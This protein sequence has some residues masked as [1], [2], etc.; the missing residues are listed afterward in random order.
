MADILLI[1]YPGY[2][3]TMRE[4]YLDNGLANLAGALRSASHNP[5]VL[6]Y[7]NPELIDWFFPYS[8]GPAINEIVA[9]L[10]A[11]QKAGKVPG[12]SLIE[13]F[14]ETDDAVNSFQEK[15]LEEFVKSEIF[16]HIRRQSP[17]VIGFKL[18][19]GEGFKFAVRIAEMIKKEFPGIL[20]V[21][22]GA[23]V[24]WFGE[25]IY[26]SGMGNVFDLLSYGEGEEIIKQIALLPEG[27]VKLEDIP[28]I[29]Y[30]K[31]PEIITNSKKL[32]ENL[33]DLPEPIY[34]P[35]VYRPMECDKKIRVL[36]I[37]ESR[38]CPNKCAF[39]IHP[40]KSGNYWRERKAV[41]VVDEMQRHVEKYRTN[42]F[43]FAGSNPPPGLKRDIAR[44]IIKRKLKVRYGAFGHARGMDQKDY[45]L[46]KE[47]GCVSLF[48][49]VE[50]GSQVIL[51]RAM[52]KGNRVEQVRQSLIMCREAGIK[53]IASVIVPAPFDNESTVN[54]TFELLAAAKPF[55]VIVNLPGALPKTAWFD[56]AARYGFDVGDRDAFIRNSMVYSIKNFYPP[57]LWR[58]L[59]GYTL[60]G[61]PAAD[62]IKTT[63]LFTKRLHAAG[64][65]TRITDDLSLIVD[66]LGADKNEFLNTTWSMLSSGDSRGIKEMI[67]K[68][69]GSIEAGMDMA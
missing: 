16:S 28:N 27:G 17:Q 61:K 14:H 33:E 63:S 58:D 20:L 5:L 65:S 46:L 13:K 30:R 24:D 60:D 43:R 57:A 50:S 54:E 69:N 11:C 15:R 59:P 48:F 64:I 45:S 37:D 6:D 9:E 53:A 42:I 4:F 10:T 56:D 41:A 39:C 8:Y 12:A 7:A 67:K 3:A 66:L 29:I 55:S 25:Q 44:E 31:G 22:G 23:Q 1:N 68:I 40:G 36:I 2:P 49:G 38:G 51:D 26:S 52:N 21:G 47:S 19:I 62:I 18:W 35:G 34:D 32:I